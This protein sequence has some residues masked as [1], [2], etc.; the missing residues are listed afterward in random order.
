MLHHPPDAI[1]VG[2][3]PHP[4][5]V[6]T[7][8]LVQPIGALGVLAA[9]VSTCVYGF[10]VTPDFFAAASHLKLF[11]SIPE[12]VDS[13][14]VVIF[15]FSCHF[16][17][18]PIERNM[19]SRTGYADLVYQATWVVIAVETLFGILGYCFFAE[20][21]KLVVLDNVQS[22]VTSEIVRLFLVFDM[23]MSAPILLSAGR[24]IVESWLQRVLSSD[25][26]GKEGAKEEK[27]G[28]SRMAGRGGTGAVAMAELDFTQK[29][30]VRTALVG[31]SLAIAQ[32]FR[33]P[34]P[35]S[36]SIISVLCGCCAQAAKSCKIV[37]VCVCVRERERERE[38]WLEPNDV[39]LFV[40]LC[41][42]ACVC[43]SSLE[44]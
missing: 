37:C 32:V 42:C 10:S 3:K 20:E 11:T 35:R 17:I 16:A 24:E 14:G 21:T 7:V 9:I 39:C 19:K 2:A 38:R 18:F 15:L 36:H 27:G 44:I 31:A 4:N 34:D 26:D 13:L 12:M 40:C 6:L 25:A 41:V 22:G 30:A 8:V 23:V 1:S 33:E 5:P 29:L 43:M 28:A